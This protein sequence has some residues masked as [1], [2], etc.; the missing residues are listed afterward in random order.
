M[1]KNNFNNPQIEEHN[2]DPL[3][4]LL[5][6][7]NIS[8]QKEN[9]KLS[10]IASSKAK[11]DTKIHLGDLHLDQLEHKAYWG[12]KDLMLAKRE[13]EALLFFAEHPNKIISFEE[14]GMH[15]FGCFDEP[16]KRSIM[17]IVS[18]LRKKM[19][20]DV[21]LENMLENIR[22]TGYRLICK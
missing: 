20:L 5:L 2:I 15:L 9:A 17:V 6:E 18:R 12:T 4:K 13:Y 10:Q 11:A 8:L 3:S 16:D 7:K 22:G 21:H 19:Q 1:K 14:L